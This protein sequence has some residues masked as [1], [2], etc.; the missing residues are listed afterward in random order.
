MTNC[1]YPVYV[2]N[3]DADNY[4]CAS[5][6]IVSMCT[7]T[8]VTVCC[9]RCGALSSLEGLVHYLG[10]H[11]TPS[12]SSFCPDHRAQLCYVAHVISVILKKSDETPPGTVAQVHTYIY[13]HVC[14]YYGVYIIHVHL[15]LPHMS[16]HF[17]CTHE[18]KVCT[19]NQASSRQLHWLVGL[20]RV[21]LVTL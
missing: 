17:Y 2:H 1:L 10:I 6:I 20:H 14:T 4:I 3:I 18:N 12:D 19:A 13:V 5:A 7:C 8:C 9:C 11:I 21:C 16:L 15:Q